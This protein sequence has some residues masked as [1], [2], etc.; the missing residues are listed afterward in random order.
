LAERQP[1]LH[2]HKS[3]HRAT[4]AVLTSRRCVLTSLHFMAIFPEAN[5]ESWA[6]DSS[7]DQ[8]MEARI[9]QDPLSIAGDT[10]HKLALSQPLSNRLCFPM[11][12]IPPSVP[13]PSPGDAV[14]PRGLGRMDAK[15]RAASLGQ[16]TLSRCSGHLIRRSTSLSSTGRLAEGPP[17]PS[18][19]GP[20][21]HI[22]IA[23]MF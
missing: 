13:R 1:K 4:L 2:V 16:L 8:E 19:N 5:S 22:Y 21:L 20:L 18:L 17:L 14:Q 7:N 23:K 11:F 6:F 12:R 15:A 9:S 3:A 10:M